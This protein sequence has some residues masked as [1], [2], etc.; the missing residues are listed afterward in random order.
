MLK[1]EHDNGTYEQR[2]VEDDGGD[3]SWLALRCIDCGKIWHAVDEIETEEY[4]SILVAGGWSPGE[5][6]G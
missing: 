1:C 6:I 4:E 3:F 5:V 2:L